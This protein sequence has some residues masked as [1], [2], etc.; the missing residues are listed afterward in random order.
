MKMSLN[1]VSINKIVSQNAK[2]N[3]GGAVC[4]IILT[5]AMTRATRKA[6]GIG[7]DGGDDSWPP[8]GEKSG[9]LAAKFDATLLSL[10]VDSKQQ[11]LPGTESPEGVD[12]NVSLVDGFSWCFEDPRDE[13]NVNVVFSFAARTTIVDSVIAITNF[14]YSK[15]GREALKG[16]LSYNKPGEGTAVDMTPEDPRQRKIGEDDEAG[17][18]EGIGLAPTAAE[19]KAA[20]KTEEAKK[21]DLRKA[22][23]SVQ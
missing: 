6:L 14:F 12:I 4:K 10:K 11:S 16:H 18:P 3:T 15:S 1:S 5:A 21:A 13:D 23:Q 2:K 8:A 20:R 7:T 9:K 19:R 22:N 17:E